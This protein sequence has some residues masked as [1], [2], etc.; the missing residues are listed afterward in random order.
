MGKL[1][2]SSLCKKKY[3]LPVLNFCSSSSWLFSFDLS[4]EINAHDC[5]NNTVA[6]VS[7]YSM[8]ISSFKQI[9]VSHHFS[10]CFNILQSLSTFPKFFHL[11]SVD[12]F[13]FLNFYF[14][15]GRNRISWYWK[16]KTDLH[17]YIHI[18]IH[19]HVL[20][21]VIIGCFDR[22]VIPQK[23]QKCPLSVI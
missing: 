19:V 10:S 8:H 18:V 21:F 2:P 17:L 1:W 15:F 22:Q 11:N 5:S 4:A 16:K 20:W 12:V 7:A 14:F 23:M 13:F 9:L 6:T 3:I